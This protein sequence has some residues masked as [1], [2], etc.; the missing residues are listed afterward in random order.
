MNPVQHARTALQQLLG[1]GMGLGIANDGS[2]DTA[3]HYN[4]DM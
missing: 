1:I 2:S 3:S 4:N